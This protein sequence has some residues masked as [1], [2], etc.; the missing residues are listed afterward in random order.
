MK[1]F[2]DCVS[3]YRKQVEKGDI[4]TAYRGLIQYMMSLRT[5]FRNRFPDYSVAGNIYSGY[6]DMTYFPMV[7]E[8]LKNKGLKIA[9]VLVHDKL[10]FEAWLAGSN[11]T[12][13]AKYWG[14][15]KKQ[16]WDK[17]RVPEVI[18]GQDS[19]IECDLV[20]NPD[21]SDMEKITKQIEDR[22]VRF[23]EDIEA[24]LDGI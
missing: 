6:M 11:K 9:I 24:F 16:K 22:T 5:H 18:K 8:K 12:M 7:P 19:I 20:V 10:R 13:Q 4:V 3:E 1:S 15:V 23:V 14:I 21:F 2:N 17:Y